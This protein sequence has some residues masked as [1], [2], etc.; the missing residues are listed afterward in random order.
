MRFFAL[1]AILFL[2][3]VSAAN[4]TPQFAD[5]LNGYNNCDT[6]QV[7]PETAV[8]TYDVPEVRL[9]SISFQPLAG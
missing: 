4:A 2:G 9:D 6:S 3:L 8:D 1:I 5:C 7:A